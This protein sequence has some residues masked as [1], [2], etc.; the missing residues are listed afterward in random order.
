LQPP[1]IAIPERELGGGIIARAKMVRNIRKELNKLPYY[2]PIHILG[3]GHPWA[4]AIF[5]AAGA[6]TFD[7]LEWCRYT[8]DEAR[9]GISHFHLYDLFVNIDNS[10]MGFSANVA[11]HNLKFLK[12]FEHLMYGYLADNKVELWVNGIINDR[13]IFL[14]LKSQ[15]PEIFE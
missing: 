9:G 5:V 2:Q 15:F 1:L 11:F 13:D 7:G 4:I 3:T 12:E 14:K 10:K 6:D 8:F